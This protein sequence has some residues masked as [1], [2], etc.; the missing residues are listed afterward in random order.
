MPLLLAVLVPVDLTLGNGRGCR[1]GIT[2]LDGDDIGDER[3]VDDDV[4]VGT[5]GGSGSGVVR[6]PS[7]ARL[8]GGELSL[9]DGG[10]L[11][12][13]CLDSRGGGGEDGDGR[14]GGE[15]AGDDG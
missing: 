9:S 7:V 1:G 15:S 8:D 14:S 2:L 4:L 11:G 6:P 12:G 10:L 13:G 3:G 5:I